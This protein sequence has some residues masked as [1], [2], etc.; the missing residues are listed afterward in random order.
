MQSPP[1]SLS[2]QTDPSQQ[3]PQPSASPQSDDPSRNFPALASAGPSSALSVV[4]PTSSSSQQYPLA[5]VAHPKLRSG[6]ELQIA[7]K[8]AA[9][10]TACLA[11]D[12]AAVM[13]PDI[14]SPFSD[15]ADV[16]NRLLPYHIFQQPHED[17]RPLMEYRPYKG[18]EKAKDYIGQEMEET[19]SALDCHRRLKKLRDRFRQVQRKAGALTTIKRTCPDGQAYVLAQAIL[20]VERA[21]T[22][23]MNSELRSARNELDAIQREKRAATQPA[24]TTFRP[25]YYPQGAP[26]SQYYR[27]YSYGYTQPYSA[28]MPGTTATFYPTPSGQQTASTAGTVPTVTS[29]STMRYTPSTGAIPVQLPVTSLSA[30]HALGIVPVPATSLPPSEQPQ[31][32]AVLKG[33]TSNG[34]MLSLDINVS[35]LQSSQ[36]S[37]LALLLNSLM[38]K[39]GSTGQAK[40]ATASSSEQAATRVERSSKSAVTPPT[41]QG[42]DDSGGTG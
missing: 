16:V 14:E 20:E 26:Q 7:Q 32:A 5:T 3:P 17:L 9:G 34:S 35:L 2:V 15:A 22:A 28:S 19:R 8:T 24:V 31:P 37:G 12:H 29:P 23:V 40:S 36:M 41:T 21:E 10:F 42:R 38:S 13:H 1:L 27:P 33:S 25:T 4:P 6:E 30:L 11:A 18:K 39:G